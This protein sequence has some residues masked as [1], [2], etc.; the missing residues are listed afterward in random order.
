VKTKAASHA[1]PFLLAAN[2][3]QTPDAGFPGDFQDLCSFA[4]DQALAIEKASQATVVSL[5]SCMLDIFGNSIDMASKSF[6]FCMELQMNWLTMFAP[7][8]FS[9]VA[10]AGRQAHPSADEVALSMDIAV[11][12]S[13][14]TEITTISGSQARPAAEPQESGVDMAMS[15]RAA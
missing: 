11:G 3:R 2:E 14:A 10:A 9:H 7:H 1:T 13:R 4:M 15:A 5:N 6:A 8:V 12:E